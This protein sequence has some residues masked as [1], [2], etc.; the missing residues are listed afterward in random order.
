MFF[1][2]LFNIIAG[3]VRVSVHGY[4]IERFINLLAGLHV[5]VWGM[6]RTG[7]AEVS[8]CLRARQFRKV[9]MPAR[10]TGVRVRILKKRGLP[11]LLYRY[12]KRKGMALGLALFFALVFYMS[13]FVWSV[14]VTGNKDVAAADIL[15]A[16]EK[17]GLRPGKPSFSLD[18]DRLEY[19]LLTSFPQ[20]IWTHIGIYG[21]KAVV[22]VKEG[23]M[24]PQ[25][26]PEDMPCNIVAAADGVVTRLTV[27]QGEAKVKEGEA[28]SKGQLLVSGVLDSKVTGMRL[29]H[30]SADIE[31]QLRYVLSAEHP[32]SREELVRTGQS[33]LRSRLSVFTANI[34][35]YWGKAAP[36]ELFEAEE[37]V[38]ELSLWKGLVLPVRYIRTTFYEQWRQ[39]VEYTVDD[40]VKGAMALLYAKE[41]ETFDSAS[42]EYAQRNTCLSDDKVTA[43][44]E[45]LC[46]GVLSRQ[47]PIELQPEE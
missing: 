22:E 7:K 16:L 41:K 39:T 35:L 28:V 21:S 38:K 8:M 31:G 2:R 20:I 23:R 9:R 33:I 17:Q 32:L 5:P 4:F 40:A 3:Y 25:I 37:T 29:V 27:Y 13:A 36:Y 11:F 18:I 44:G 43:E 47:E 6:K 19:E 1:P 45:Y 46:A 26:V 34:P 42:L 15:S 14:E 10:K 30:A 12:R 24:P